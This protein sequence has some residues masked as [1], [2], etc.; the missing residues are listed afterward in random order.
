M[1]TLST[2][3]ALLAVL[4]TV[5]AA[6]AASSDERIVGGKT[7]APNSVPFMANLKIDGGLMCGA[8]LVTVN[9]VISAA[10]CYYSNLMDLTVTV[11]DVSLYDYD[12]S[13]QIFRAKR[14]IVH[15]DYDPS[16]FHND[17]MLI[18]IDGYAQLNENVKTI[19][20][21]TSPPSIGTYCSVYGWGYTDVNGPVSDSL[22]G[23]DLP[24]ISN[25][26]CQTYYG[27]V[28]KDE[29][30]CLGR[31]DYNSGK[32]ACSGDSGGPAVCNGALDGIV[33]YGIGCADAR[34]PGVYTRVSM[35]NDWIVKVTNQ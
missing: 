2:V 13:E 34:Y 19:T 26:E 15:E 27:S 30:F 31:V 6:P 32:D 33:S 14:L 24:V 28:V 21:A 10:H 11:G 16:I 35:Y 3:C 18:E 20:P 22:L 23:V 1:T 8:S 9:Y 5:H 25:T 29:E 7:Q 4:V 12:R 17:I